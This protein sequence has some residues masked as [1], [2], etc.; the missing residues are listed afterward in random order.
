MKLY[1]VLLY[2][3]TFYPTETKPGKCLFGLETETIFLSYFC[4]I[5]LAVTYKHFQQD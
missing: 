1:L 3:C 4:F 5:Y 2:F